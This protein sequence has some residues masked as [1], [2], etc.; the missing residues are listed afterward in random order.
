MQNKRSFDIQRLFTCGLN[1]GVPGDMAPKL[2]IRDTLLGKSKISALVREISITSS[3]D[4]SYQIRPLASWS[5]IDT[6][7]TYS[8]LGTETT[9]DTSS[10]FSVIF[11]CDSSKYDDDGKIIPK[12]YL[13]R[14]QRRRSI[15]GT[16][17]K[18]EE[19]KRR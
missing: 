15:P 6:D 9:K 1:C 13:Q 17:E 12:Y 2:S 14:L 11:D 18:E 8:S 19:K 3:L 5:T 4:D 7:S 10:Y 16:E